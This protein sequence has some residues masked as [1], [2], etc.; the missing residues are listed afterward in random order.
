MLKKIKS[1]YI[2]IAFVLLAFITMVALSYSFMREIVY[3]HIVNHANNTIEAEHI[4]VE[5]VISESKLTFHGFS[6]T[7]NDMILQGYSFSALEAYIKTL[8]EYLMIETAAPDDFGYV[9]GWF[10]TLDGEEGF[11]SGIDWIPGADYVPQE[12]PWFIAAVAANGGIA[13]EEPY[14]DARTGELVYSFSRALFCDDGE[15][16]GVASIDVPLQSVADDIV[17]ASSGQGGYGMLA[18]GDFIILSH[19]NPEYVGMSMRDPNFPA[20]AMTEELERIGKVFEYEMMSFKGEESLAFFQRLP[21]GWYL[22]F[23]TPKAQYFNDV[24]TMAVTLTITGALLALVLILILIYI[25]RMREKA[26]YENKQKSAFLANMSHEIRTP[27]NAI[28]GMTIIGKAASDAQ[29]MMYCFEKI[30][31]AS[32]HLLGVINDV[33]DMSKIEANKFELSYEEFNFEKMLQRVIN[34]VGF[35]ATERKQELTVFIDKS[36]PRRLIGDDNRIAQVI[37]NLLGNAVKFTPEEGSIKLDT[38]FVALEDGVYTIRVTIT[39]TGI[40][41]TPEQQQKLFQSFQQAESNTTRKFGGTGLGLA[42]SKRIVEMMG[43]TIEVESEVGKGSSFSFTFQAERGTKKSA[44]LSE[45]GVNWNNVSIMAV[46]DDVEILDYFVDVM[47][48][49][50]TSCD[51][52]KSG[53]EALSLI[54]QNGMYDIYFVDWKMPG[55]DGLALAQEI[56]AKSEKPDNTVVIMISAAEWCDIADEAKAAGVDRFL[57]KPLFPSAIADA[58][59][60]V[61]GVSEAKNNKHDDDV[62]GIFK[63]NRILLTEDVEVNREVLMALLEATELKID[64]AVDGIEA[65]NKFAESPDNYYDLIF[66]DVQMPKMD[67]HEATREIRKLNHSRAKAVPIIAMTAN[68]FKEDIEQCAESGMNGHIGKPIDIDELFRLLRK[69]L[70]TDR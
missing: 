14:P 46:D 10:K 7:V 4:M 51:T 65:I 15:L 45:I 27:M 21:N 52:A 3:E 61:I 32:Q 39:D 57:S 58:I 23:V 56:K 31:N 34:I 48:G 68:V 62:S 18:S 47:Q 19:P 42:I 22:G 63:E 70:L 50:G 40:G 43:G 38:R 36:I 12:R 69:Y 1:L 29:R 64:C 67:G 26:D 6:S 9:Y 30:E 11:I 20:W 5:T 33:L 17:E 49:F 60:E 2:Q 24:T 16:I 35:R 13:E 54:G 55:M 25:D 8:C 44:N 53:M 28:I 41:I 37:T 66:M 59:T